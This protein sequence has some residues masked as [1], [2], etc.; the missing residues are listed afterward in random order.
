[1]LVTGGAG[2]I[3]SHLVDNLLASG[4]EVVVIDDLSS[5]KRQNLQ[6]HA[7]KRS[8]RLVKGSV[9]DRSLVRRNLDGV[10]TVFHLAAISNVA[11]SVLDPCLIDRVNVGGTV[12]MLDEARRKGVS[13]FV[14]ASSAAV[15]GNSYTPPLSE[16]MAPAP[17]SPYGA[18]KASCEDYCNSFYRAYGLGT[19]VL[20][21]FNVY[22]PRSTEGDYSAVMMRFAQRLAAGSPLVIY[23]DG[24]QTRDFVNVDDVVR[25]SILAVRSSRA[26]GD[27]FNVGTGRRI[28]VNALAKIFLREGRLGQDRVIREKARRGEIRQSWAAMS[29][30]RR[31]I[32]FSAK[33]SISAGVRRFLRW[34]DSSSGG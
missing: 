10:S 17:D 30:P 34:Y 21:Y 22:G 27:T 15:Y 1:M 24:N 14:L 31:V 26:V 18:S 19:V 11:R 29:K 13:R 2:F 16:E 33:T 6:L 28:S 5:G 7:G 32:G 3:G 12:T 20:R 25:A 8:F 4:H 9:C 23:G